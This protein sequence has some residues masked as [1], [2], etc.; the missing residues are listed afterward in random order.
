MA[1]N[2]SSLMSGISIILILGILPTSATAFDPYA[3][4]VVEFERIDGEFFDTTFDNGDFGHDALGAPAVDSSTSANC[5]IEPFDLNGCWTSPG[6]VPGSWNSEDQHFEP[7]QFGQLDPSCDDSDSSSCPRAGHLTVGFTDN[8]CEINQSGGPTLRVWEVGAK[9]EGFQVE[10]LNDGLP[11]GTTTSQPIQQ[12]TNGPVEINF[13]GSGFFDQ[14]RIT[15][16]DNG[17]GQP[18]ARTT[19]G[20]DIDAIE[21][22]VA[23][24]P[25]AITGCTRTQ[26]YWRT[27]SQSG[28]APFDDTWSELEDGANTNFFESP[29]TYYEILWTPVR[30]NAYLILGQ[31]YIASEL[32]IISGASMPAGVVDAFAEAQ[33]LL[34]NYA[35]EAKIDRKNPDRNR[36]IGLA[37]ILDEYN[38]GFSEPESCG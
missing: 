11:V 26:G 2:S 17:G 34:E 36:A 25:D 33:A 24:E 10:L 35:T 29:Y 38:N 7:D 21:C 37:R 19:S 6:Y 18:V 20:P 22:V 1:I 16:T 14:V 27:H 30:G 5:I 12:S 23:S 8:L 9:T 32:N 15:P 4:E 28:P 3:D 13:N 31:Q